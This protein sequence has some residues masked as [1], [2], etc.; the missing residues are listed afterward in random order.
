MKGF[1]LNKAEYQKLTDPK[2]GLLHVIHATAA[3]MGQRVNN[4]QT[5]YLHHKS[6]GVKLRAKYRLPK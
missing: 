1:P 6:L 5:Y 3:L 4:E 2:R